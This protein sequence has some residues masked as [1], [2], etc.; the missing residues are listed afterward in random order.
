MLPADPAS[1]ARARLAVFRFD[2]L[3]GADYYAF[4]RGEP[5]ELDQKLEALPVG[6]SLF[7]DFAFVPWL[8]RLRELTDLELPDRIASWLAGLEA[9]PSVAAEVALMRAL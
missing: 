2:E 3:F 5:N 4:R 6:E 1:R 7:A 9:R 8:I